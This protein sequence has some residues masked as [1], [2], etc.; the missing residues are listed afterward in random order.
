MVLNIVNNSAKQCKRQVNKL[1][2]KYGSVQNRQMVV[3]NMVVYKIVN[4]SYSGNTKLQLMQVIS[5]F[6]VV[7]SLMFWKEF[8]CPRNLLA[9]S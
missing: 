5:S 9:S 8:L 4:F 3:Y 2:K 7:Q 1:M 6:Y